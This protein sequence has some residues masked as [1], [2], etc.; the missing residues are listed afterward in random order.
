MFLAILLTQ[1]QNKQL[2]PLALIL[3]GVA[4]KFVKGVQDILHR[5]L[6]FK[7]KLMTLSV[8]YFYFSQLDTCTMVVVPLVRKFCENV[9]SRDYQSLR[10]V[11]R[12]FGKLCYGLS[13]G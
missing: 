13:G 5:V 11:A 7:V 6:I 8:F 12:L 1:G 9:P 3:T 4:G 2:W 10:T